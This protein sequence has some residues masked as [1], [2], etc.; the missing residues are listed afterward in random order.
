VV[1]GDWNQA[2]VRY[3]AEHIATTK[4]TNCGH[5]C[6]ATQV[7]VVSQDWPLADKLVAEVGKVIADAEPRPTYYPGS[8][9]ET[10]KACDGM[11]G[12]EFLSGDRCRVLLPDVDPR[13]G[14][15]ILRD[16]VFASV[17]GVVRLPGKTPHE[18]LRN[19]VEFANDVLPGTLAADI[20][21][22][23]KTRKQNAA[24]F[25]EAISGLRYGAI[26]VN[27]WPG[28]GFALGYTPW[29]AFPGNTRHHIGS[30]TGMVHNAFLLPRPQKAIIEIP[31]RPSPRSIFNGE[32]T[33]SPKP[34]FFTTNK[35]AQTTIRRFAKFLVNGNPIALPGIITSAVR[36]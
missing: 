20:V 16:E 26:G 1:P 18:F 27:V 33:L 22:D 12:T 10:D 8:D 25:D 35:T 13:G 7:L 36:G 32:L 28:L 6:N 2:D 3:Q 29:G 17:L 19:A 9:E 4:L 24:A 21:I 23:P 34:V 11:S 5:N 31:F 14:A 30:G 15:S